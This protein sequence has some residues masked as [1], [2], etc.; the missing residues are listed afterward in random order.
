M[1][2]R[3]YM[4][5]VYLPTTQMSLWRLVDSLGRHGLLCELQ[6]GR[7]QRHTQ[8]NDVM[9]R[10]LTT[11]EFPSRLKPTGLCRKDRKHLDGLT[12][13]PFKQGKCLLWNATCVSALAEIYIT[14]TLEIPGSAAQKAKIAL[15]PE[16]A[17]DYIFTP[18][19]IETLAHGKNMVSILS[20]KYNKNYVTSL[21]TKDQHFTCSNAAS[22]LGTVSSS[23]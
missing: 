8:I 5:S 6:A 4:S 7:P 14:Q 16:L 10:A 13:F 15:Y 18:I 17:K 1:P 22:I 19:A 9:K 2:V 23:T 21:V 11:A 20:K 12:L 3:R